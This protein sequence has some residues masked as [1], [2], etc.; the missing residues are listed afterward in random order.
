[1]ETGLARRASPVG[2]G[3]RLTPGGPLGVRS[4]WLAGAGDR[5][6]AVDIDD[7]YGGTTGILKD[8][9]GTWAL[10]GSG[11]TLGGTLSHTTACLEL[12]HCW[13]R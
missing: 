2:A 3:A 8:G 4:L 13:G 6:M 11:R 10:M 9:V 12:N 7:G 1:M 5:E